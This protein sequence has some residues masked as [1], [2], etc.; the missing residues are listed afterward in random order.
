M[1]DRRFQEAASMALGP[2]KY[3]D[4]CIYVRERTGGGV[5]LIVVGGKDGGGFACRADLETTM[6]AAG[7]S[8]GRGGP[9]ARR[10]DAVKIGNPKICNRSPVTVLFWVYRETPG[11]T[12]VYAI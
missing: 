7:P 8:G 11:H 10:H 5:L 12:G 2:G 9:N 4:L 3:D 1:P 6:R